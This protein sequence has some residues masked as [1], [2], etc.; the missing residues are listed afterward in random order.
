MIA[1]LLCAAALWA[2]AQL[3]STLSVEVRDVDGELRCDLAA[4]QMPLEE[5]LGELARRLDLRLEG[6]TDE[7]RDV[8]VS[9]RLRDRS[10]ED[11]LELVL[12]SVGLAWERRSDALLVRSASADALEPEDMRRIALASYLRTAKRFP[13]H[14]VAPRVAFG[15]GRVEEAR[16]NSGAAIDHYVGLS[17]AYPESELVPEALLRAGALL[18]EQ[19]Q[20]HEAELLLA[21][22]LRLKPT[23]DLDRGARLLMVRCMAFL[24]DPQRTVYALDALDSLHPPSEP[25]D[26]QERLY[27]RARAALGLRRPEEA[28][29][30]LGQADELGLD[31]DGERA[32]SL[33][34]RARILEA[35]GAPG[36][37][38]RSWLAL[39]E[40]APEPER[41]DAWRSAARLALEAGD[42]LGALLVCEH[43]RAAGAGDAVGEQARAARLGLGLDARWQGSTAWQQRLARAERLLDAGQTAEADGLLAELHPAP[44]AAEPAVVR[45]LALAYARTRAALGSVDAALEV[46]REALA[47]LEDPEAR[48]SLYLLAGELLED[49]GRWNAAVEA[50]RGR[51]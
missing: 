38:A 42:E 47:R 36:E 15:Q 10:V 31:D 49:D 46:L 35:S 22:L 33:E 1:P 13:R 29:A 3:A 2:P 4:A 23:A 7:R 41:P 45:R 21:E 30:L 14:P 9:V 48:R 51:L 34:L 28:L 17:E 25:E 40:V 5:V 19:R 32:E 44:S 12:G 6:L 20:W 39:A 16:G 37:A 18:V 43:A 50:Y 24:D 8:R 11:A 26:L 27:L